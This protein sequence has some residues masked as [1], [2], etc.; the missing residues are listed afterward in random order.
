LVSLNCTT[1]AREDRSVST[2]R[3]SA[4]CY[5][6]IHLCMNR[7]PRGLKDHNHYSNAL[8]DR[9]LISRGCLA[10]PFRSDVIWPSAF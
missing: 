1:G 8:P 7:R 2:I 10:G 4:S 9:L 5:P 3:I 6:E